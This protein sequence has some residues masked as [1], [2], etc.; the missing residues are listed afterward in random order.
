MEKTKIWEKYQAG[1]DHHN[2]VGM[3]QQVE[4]CHRFYEGDQ[5]HG[6]KTGGEELPSLNFL[7]PV[8]R[9]QIATVA[10]NEL[11]IVFSSLSGDEQ[12][13]ELCDVL[14]RY[15][16]AQVE[17]GKL[18]NKKWSVVKGAC[19]TGDHYLYVYDERQPSE[20]VVKELAPSLRHRLIDKDNVYLANEQEPELQ[21][22]EWIILAERVPVEQVRRTAKANGLEGELVEQIA[23]DEDLDRPQ[24]IGREVKTGEGKCTSLL[25]MEKTEEGIRFCRSTQNV[26]YQPEKTLEGMDVYPL[27]AMRWEE[28]H[29]SARG[30]GVVERLIPNQI[31]VNKTL[32]R[33]ALC[34]KRYGY[35]TAV[36]DPTKVTN[37]GDLNKVGATI[38]VQNLG[39]NPITSMI[40]YLNPAPMSSDAASLEGELVTQSRELEGA[41]DAATGQVD[42]TQASGEAIKAARDQSALNLN[43]QTA[44]FKQF[45][46]DLAIIWYKLW[47]VYSSAGLEVRYSTD[48]GGLV[49][50]VLD[51]QALKNADIDIRIDISPADPYSVLSREMALENALTAGHITFAEYVEAL[52][53]QGGV[54]KE[55]L[56]A[57]LDRRE[58]PKG[59]AAME[60]EAAALQAA[61]LQLPPPLQQLQ[62]GGGIPGGPAAEAVPMAAEQGGA[63]PPELLEMLLTQKGGDA[64]AL[65]QMQV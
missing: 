27:A 13:S 53:S 2:R 38:K 3:Y 65:P 1:R 44:N 17:K 18:D 64:N 32:A 45:M 34:V 42:P 40:Q 23:A 21:R 6:L 20:S 37:A 48:Q 7:K 9:Y 47:V 55:K 11:A 22:Q 50:Q 5:W 62:A 60:Q 46:E 29:G 30:V 51:Q 52:D 26:V 56:K 19:I 49:Q 63:L 35:P 54:P 28:K 8:C 43:E 57:I 41:G 58:T 59:Q 14:T 24:K 33:R 39:T 16:A 31:E 12:V 36:I 15:A 4:R 10:M 25:Y 61:G